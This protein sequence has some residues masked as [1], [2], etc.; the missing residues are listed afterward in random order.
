[1]HGS[2]GLRVLAGQVDVL[3]ATLKARRS[4]IIDVADYEKLTRYD[5]FAPS[6]HPLPV[7]HASSTP[8][9]EAVTLRLLDRTE[10]GLDSFT[11]VLMLTD[12]NLGIDDID[13]VLQNAGMGCANDMWNVSDHLRVSA[14]SG[15]SL[16]WRGHSW[17]LVRQL[18]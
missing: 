4:C 1:M 9:R 14:G 2:F 12:S 18:K 6:S 13:K 16:V 3:G 15:G 5:V 11:A 10:F 7:I 17:T 8:R